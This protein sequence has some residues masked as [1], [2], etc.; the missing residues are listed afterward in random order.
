MSPDDSHIPLR[1]TLKQSGILTMEIPMDTRIRLAEPTPTD[2][3]AF[4]QL[5]NMASHDVLADVMGTDFEQALVAMFL[6]DDNLY[7][8]RQSRFLEVG[9][10]IAG[11]L[12]AFSG[13]QKAD[14]NAETDRQFLS[15]PG[16]GSE[17]AVQVRNQL[18]PISD[19]IDTVP[20]EAFYI[21]FLAVYPQAR[22]KGYAR[23]LMALANDLAV[24]HGAKTL[25][26]D[27]ETGNQPALN[28]Y[29]GSGLRIIRTSP[30]V[31]YDKQNRGLALHRMAKVTA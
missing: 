31:T 15:F 24:D 25:E 30:E 9:H 2:A 17:S 6:R 21:Q 18:Q 20:I 3:I 11:M 7:S 1:S 28:A 22:G 5:A 13:Q 29:L 27:V 16:A 12:C 4:A 19:F 23:Q 10:D 26:L 8:Y 14:L